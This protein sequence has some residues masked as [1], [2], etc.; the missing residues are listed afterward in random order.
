MLLVKYEYWRDM[1]TAAAHTDTTNLALL[2]AQAVDDDILTY[3][4]R[5]IGAPIVV[6][7]HKAQVEK[8]NATTKK[9]EVTTLEVIR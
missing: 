3:I 7:D 5:V 2:S 4:G 1:Y 6:K 9:V 8:W